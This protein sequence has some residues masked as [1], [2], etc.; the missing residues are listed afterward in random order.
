MNTIEII[1]TAWP[2]W[3]IVDDEPLGVGSFGCVYRAERRDITGVTQAAIKIIS[4]PK[5]KAELNAL[6]RE[7]MSF[8]ETRT[9]LEKMVRSVGAEIRLMEQVKGF[10]NIVSI[11]DYKVIEHPEIPQ[12]QILMRMELLKPLPEAMPES[13][14]IQLGKDICSAL[15]I[16]RKKNIVHRDIKPENIFINNVGF[17]KLGDF[18]VARTMEHMT[19]GFTR[20][21]TY[22][23]MAP[24]IFNNAIQSADIDAAVKVDIY[25]L[26]MV[27]YALCNNGRIPFV[28]TDV[29]LDPDMR[30]KAIV[31]RMKGEALPAPKFASA[32]LA[33]V[34]MK[35]CAF[36]PQERYASAEAFREALEHIGSN[37]QTPQDQEKMIAPTPNPASTREAYHNTET[38]R[39]EPE[40]MPEPQAADTN[41]NKQDSPNTSGI[42]SP[43]REQEAHAQKDEP[44]R[45]EPPRQEREIHVPKPESVKKEPSRQAINQHKPT[46][47]KGEPLRQDAAWQKPETIRK[48]GFGSE[49][50]IGLIVVCALFL[51][52]AVIGVL[53]KK[54][55]VP[56][57][58]TENTVTSIPQTGEITDSSEETTVTNIPQTNEIS[59]SWE[60]II[61]AI[62]DGSARQ[63][64][65]VGTTKELDLGSLG[66][67]HMQ[68]AGFD[69]DERADGQGKAATTWI[70]VELLPEKRRM[71]VN[72]NSI[73]TWRD[74]DLRK[75]LQDTVLPSMPLSIRQ[76]MISVIKQQKNGSE[77]QTTED[78]IW[79]PD[80]EEVF[81]NDALYYD[82]FLNDNENRIKY[83][84]D[85]ATWWWLR[86][87]FNNNNFRGVS[88]GGSNYYYSA[89]NSGGG[90]ALG[91]CLSDNPSASTTV[92][93]ESKTQ[94]YETLTK[95]NKSNDVLR[96]QKRL[97]ELGYLTGDADSAYGNKTQTAVKMF[98]EHVGIEV[99]GIADSATQALLFSDA[100][101]KIMLETAA[102]EPE[103]QTSEISDSWEEIVAAIDGGSARQRYAVGA[104]KELDLGNLGT[105]HMQL[106][107]FDL[108]E[109][110][111]GQGEAATT[112]IAIEL[113][114]EKQPMGEWNNGWKNSDLR[115]H[116]HRTLLPT[117]PLIIQNRVVSVIKKQSIGSMILNTV[118]QIWIPDYT[119]LFGKN[120]LYSGL[121]PSE[122]KHLMKQIEGEET[123]WWLRSG[124]LYGDHYY[125]D[126]NG[127]YYSGN[128]GTE[129]GVLLGFCL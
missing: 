5:D 42:G 72:P 92:M 118:D 84:N 3:R 20:T 88:S 53:S 80:Y 74:S 22:N 106:A 2:D 104:T 73:G 4:I 58:N 46:E 63:R 15:A 47:P 25:S 43:G 81:G 75:Y 102:P 36:N 41:Q 61:A 24:E 16:C 79:I 129:G 1:Q 87:A 78:T 17:Y 109:R 94:E 52:V 9:Y 93:E 10:T 59:D 116:L 101:P 71:N 77:W 68:L 126:T 107:G 7:G 128:P 98:Q 86:S 49:V 69:L 60:E 27:L 103:M 29:A 64:Y 35:A 82:F 50:K 55:Q 40:V 34:I 26:G 85:Y 127:N 89:S 54:N 100:A 115:M 8:E 62:D 23:Y 48:K 45:Q 6:R 122:G 37:T 65:A 39:I 67:V 113:L 76:H 56:E 14:I 91:F 123:W 119:E 124:N 11:E 18:G 96:L 99:T 108:D 28:P 66:I 95:G 120:S 121:F 21:G 32:G 105:I 13:E 12:W 117:L 31:R 70:A 125:V 83:W 19:V 38:V 90:V 111:D 112:W 44:N 30:T 33:A 57:N 97:I 114:P 110:A 51:I